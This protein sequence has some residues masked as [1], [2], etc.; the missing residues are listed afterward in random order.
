MRIL[1]IADGRSPT[2]VN[3]I[4]YFVARGDQVHLVSTFPASPDLNL[5]SLHILPLAF[6]QAASTPQGA[7]KAGLLKRL[8]STR[9]RTKVRQWF[10]PLTL[11]RAAR[12]LRQIIADV[13]P[14]LVHALRI[15]YEGML[16]ALADP[17]APLIVS[18]W[19]NDFT[20]HGE[21]TPL[22]R[23]YTRRTV[24]RI[25]ALLADCRRDIRLAK[26]WGFP[27]EKPNLVLPGA[28]GLQPDIFYPPPQPVQAPLVI[29]PRGL[30]AYVRNDT[31]F[32]ALPLVLAARP[33]ARF[34]CNTMAGEPQAERWVSEL[35]LEDV[36]TLLPLQSREAMGDLF[37]KA[38]VVVSPSEHDGTPNSLL[39]AVACGCF[40]VAGDIESIREWITDG[41]N[42]LLVDPGDPAALADAILRGLNDQALRKKAG[43]INQALIAERAE[44]GRVMGQA[45]AF[46]EG[47][48]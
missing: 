33:E 31:F 32:K 13:R 10:G 39:E 18:V 14:D 8:V 4:K 29:N 21:A 28:G 3:W 38:Q 48:V 42:G 46:Y 23:A 25:D 26:E 45:G 2:A 27:T 41:E 20:L 6:S 7:G 35:G 43:E 12:A 34:L 9:A 36:V 5:A 1:F 40:P 37:R 24:Q 44:Y 11:P 16:A 47:I 15:P 30:R 22:M 19:G 17:A